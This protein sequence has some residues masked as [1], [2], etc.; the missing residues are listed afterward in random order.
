MLAFAWTTTFDVRFT[1]SFRSPVD[2]GSASDKVW[3]HFAGTDIFSNSNTALIA[4]HAGFS[5][6]MY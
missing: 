3:A 4:T 1:L 5:G 6:G 2:F